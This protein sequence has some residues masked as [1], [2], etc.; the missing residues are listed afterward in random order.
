MGGLGS[1]HPTREDKGD[2]KVQCVPHGLA[3]STSGVLFLIVLSVRA[4]TG[5]QLQARNGVGA[6]RGH[7]RGGAAR[8]FSLRHQQWCHWSRETPMA[9]SSS[10]LHNAPKYSNRGTCDASGAVAGI[11]TSPR[12]DT[13]KCHCSI[14]DLQPC[15]T[16]P[17]GVCPFPARPDLFHGWSPSAGTPPTHVAAGPNALLCESLPELI[18]S[19]ALRQ[20]PYLKR[21]LHIKN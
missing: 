1:S 14:T 9:L 4:F 11:S 20:A 5:T 16:S 6:L 3:T 2:E 8:A 12:V 19:L 13:S 15:D 17:A 10:Q 7:Q 18:I 21:F